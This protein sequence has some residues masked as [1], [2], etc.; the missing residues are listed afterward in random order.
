M[1]VGEWFYVRLV[2]FQ[3]FLLN[4]W[5][6]PSTQLPD[7]SFAKNLPYFQKSIIVFWGS[8]TNIS[9]YLV[10]WIVS[11]LVETVKYFIH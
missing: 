4:L 1:A 9:V 10:N 6:S 8:T 3:L 5:P 11:E 7:N 2:L